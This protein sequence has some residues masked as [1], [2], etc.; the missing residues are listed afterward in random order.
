[1]VVPVERVSIPRQDR[2]KFV[3]NNLVLNIESNDSALMLTGNNCKVKLEENSGSIKVVGDHCELMV[4]KG[5]GNIKYI[6]NYGKIRLGLGMS[7]DVVRYIGND[8]YISNV[9]N[10]EADSDS[11]NV[12]NKEK[13]YKHSK[14]NNKTNGDTARSKK[15]ETI[16]TKKNISIRNS[17]MIHVTTPCIPEDFEVAKPL[18]SRDRC[19]HYRYLLRKK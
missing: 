17:N 2:K 4:L 12:K 7:S 6:G 8:G 19:S 13:Q 1:M 14:S 11:D 10:T 16:D 3:G 9:A 5:K 15:T 18:P